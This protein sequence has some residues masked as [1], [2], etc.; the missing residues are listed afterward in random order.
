MIFK[1]RS[2]DILVQASSQE[3]TLIKLNL[4]NV[5]EVNLLEN[6]KNTSLGTKKDIVSSHL[7][8]K[9]C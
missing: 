9:V 2:T 6:Y 5:I 8:T 1:L 4:V 3:N 7:L